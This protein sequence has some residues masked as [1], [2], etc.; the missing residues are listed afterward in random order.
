VPSFS[1]KSRP[2]AGRPPSD[3]GA[4]G[5]LV[6]LGRLPEDGVSVSTFS[7]TTIHFSFESAA[8]IFLR[9]RAEADR[10]HAEGD[11]A[12]G[13]GLLAAARVEMPRYMSS[14]MYIQE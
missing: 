4:S 5:G 8:T 6:L 3:L 7:T 9:V 13:P 2:G 12:L 14:K 1:A 10:V 11:E